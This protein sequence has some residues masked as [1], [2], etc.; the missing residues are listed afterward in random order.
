M[1]AL[2]AVALAASGCGGRSVTVRNATSKSIEVRVVHDAFLSGDRTLGSARI[3]PDSTE[4][5]GPFKGVPLLDPVDVEV[6]FT[7][8]VGDLPVKHRVDKKNVSLVVESAGLETWTGL[9]IRREDRRF[10]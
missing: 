10:R 2:T 5:F 1:A 9:A 3:A 4:S 7:S 6:S 8:S